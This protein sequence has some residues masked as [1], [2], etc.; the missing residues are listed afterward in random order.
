M[1][2]EVDPLLVRDVD[3]LCLDAGNTVIFLD[4]AR[5]ARFVTANGNA[6]SVEALV[7]GEGEAKRLQ[8]EHAMCDFDWSHRTAPGGAGWGKMVG[9]MLKCAGI[10]ADALPRLVSRLWDEHV[11]LNLWSLVPEGFGEA[12]DRI[13][14][15]GV[16]TAVVSNSEG[17]LD[18]LFH[19]L[20][21]SKHI[22]VLV[23][24]GEV[25]VEK[26]DPRIF[27]IALEKGRATKERALHLGDSYAT[28]VLG[29]RA[30]GIRVALIDP[31]GHMAGRH[32][33]VPRVPGAVAVSNALARARQGL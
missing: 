14:A 5:V 7:R 20:G 22:D 33:D 13:R 6:V 2:L 30:A 3:L 12:M 18:S 24:S 25:G 19:R 21:V 8:E 27:A 11:A 4:H 17:M 15:L 26:P 32:L 28:D 9:T 23:D 10:P 1:S 16:R 29:A 31:H